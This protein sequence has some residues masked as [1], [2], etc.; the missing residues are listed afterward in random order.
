MKNDFEIKPII[1]SEE[2]KLLNKW[3]SNAIK[4]YRDDLIKQLE[5]SFGIPEEMVYGEYK[6]GS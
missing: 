3:Y 6:F 2:T 1:L 5:K 4:R